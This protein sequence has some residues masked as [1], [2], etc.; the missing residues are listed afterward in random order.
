MAAREC[1]LLWHGGSSY[2]PGDIATD[3][4]RFP[5]LRALKDAFWQRLGD[6]YYPCVTEAT[7][8][9][10]GQ[11][12]WVFFYDPNDESNGPGD[13]YPDRVI[14]HGPRGGIRLEHA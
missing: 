1:W 13:P 2:S 6:R 12:G 9:E 7:Q 14:C 3:L 5:S 8:E 4:E 10:G 11:S